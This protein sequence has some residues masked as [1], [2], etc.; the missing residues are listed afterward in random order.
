MPYDQTKL[1][2]V[3]ASITFPRD[4][5]LVTQYFSEYKENRVPILDI[6]YYH[7]HRFVC[8]MGRE[9]FES[10]NTLGLWIIPWDIR[11]YV[12]LYNTN[13][14]WVEDTILSLYMGREMSKYFHMQGEAYWAGRK[15]HDVGC[16]TGIFGMELTRLGAEVIARTCGPE[17]LMISACNLIEHNFDLDLGFGIE[18]VENIE[19]DS[20]TYIFHDIFYEYGIAQMNADTMRYL[21]GLGK[22]VIFTAPWHTRDVVD[23]VIPRA[24]E[25]WYQPMTLDES[26]YEVAFST[27][28]DGDPEGWGPREVLRMV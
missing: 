16:G 1:D 26:E 14:P 12:F 5:E 24:G 4:I 28:F 19:T 17:A 9:R 2:A 7:P 13:D 15:V 21:A 6:L 11:D 3:L 18:C 10:E 20:D 27:E 25:G 23:G 8:V 22:E